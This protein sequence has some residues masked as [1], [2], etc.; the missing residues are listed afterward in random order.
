MKKIIPGLLF[1]LH[2]CTSN[3]DQHE[4]NS[5][6]QADLHGYSVVAA[7]YLKE[8]FVHCI[9]DQ[10]LSQPIANEAQKRDHDI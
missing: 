1:H 2:R 4:H 10:L 8:N 5:R 3:H 6:Y 9:P 7:S